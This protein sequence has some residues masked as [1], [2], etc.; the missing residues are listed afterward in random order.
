MPTSPIRRGGKPTQRHRTADLNQRGRKSVWQ[1]FAINAC[2]TVPVCG[3]VTLHMP[4]TPHDPST[5]IAALVF[6]ALATWLDTH[7]G[8]GCR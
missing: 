8:P 5:L 7:N 6:T 1:S 2:A 3:S 4:Q